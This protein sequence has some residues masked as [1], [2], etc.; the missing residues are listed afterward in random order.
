[1]GV[2]PRYPRP[3]VEQEIEGLI[4]LLRGDVIPAGSYRRGCESVGDIDLV[5]CGISRTEATDLLVSHGLRLQEAGSPRDHFHMDVSWMSAPLSVDVWTPSPG[6]VGACVFHATGPGMH[7]AIMRRWAFSHGYSV[8]WR[9]VQHLES[10]EWV[11]GA[12]EQ[13][14]CDVI[15]WPCALPEHR[16]R[17][18]EWVGP[19]LDILN[20]VEPVEDRPTVA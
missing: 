5:L 16:E 10:G 7:N 6:M 13:E 3:L 8:T 11:A 19:Y 15:G 18:A 9:G 14:I 1:M 2:G 4:L 12:T 17:F 20:G